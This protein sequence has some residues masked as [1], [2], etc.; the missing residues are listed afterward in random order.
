MASN[1][2]VLNDD[3]WLSHLDRMYLMFE[4]LL[5]LLGGI[6]ILLVVFLAVVNILGRWIFNSPVNGYIDWVVTAM[7]FIAFLGLSYTQ[8]EGGHIRMDIVVGK[9]KARL[10]WFFEFLSILV[11]LVMTGFLANGSFNHFLRAYKIGDSTFDINLPV[12]P[13]KLIVFIAFVILFLRLLLQL[14]GYLRALYLG[15]DHPVAVP[16]VEDAATVAAREAASVESSIIDSIDNK[17]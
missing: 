13:S 2:T 3:S 11:M 8:R 15:G 4:K 14:W 9:M 16:L 1:A 10:L 7:P 12:W 5:T 6:A 17:E